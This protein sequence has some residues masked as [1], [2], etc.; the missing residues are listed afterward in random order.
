ID[1][2]D[3]AQRVSRRLRKLALYMTLQGGDIRAERAGVA[4]EF[5]HELS[6]IA[7]LTEEQVG[8]IYQDIE[9]KI[10]TTRYLH[11]PPQIFNR[12]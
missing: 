3:A 10:R 4:G 9:S 1:I 7:E 2:S 11:M 12:K 5:A 6:S 8:R